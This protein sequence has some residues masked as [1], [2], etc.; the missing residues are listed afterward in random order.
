MKRVLFSFATCLALFSACTKTANYT[1]TCS[2][3]AKSFKTDVLPIFQSSCAK[4][5]SN[6]GSYASISGDDASIK[7]KIVDGSMPK[8]GSLTNAQKDDIICWINNGS[9]NN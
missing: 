7:S 9:P 4:C 1:A 3:T 5:H 2:G 6:F 8:S